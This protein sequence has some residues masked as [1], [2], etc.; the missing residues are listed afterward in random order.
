MTRMALSRR[1]FLGM[2]GAGFTAAIYPPQPIS[3]QRDLTNVTTR[4][5]AAADG[6][7]SRKLYRTS[8]DGS[9]FTLIATIHDNT[10]R[11]YTD[12]LP[13]QTASGS[14]ASRNLTTAY[15]YV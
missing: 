1:G 10:T 15:I 13:L 8:A 3:F 6:L 14:T 5:H 11:T 12:I 4:L 7:R 2:I 9:S